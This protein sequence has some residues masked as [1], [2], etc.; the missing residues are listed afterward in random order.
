MHLPTKKKD[1]EVFLNIQSLSSTGVT[2]EQIQSVFEQFLVNI[3]INIA[4]GETAYFPFLGD[5]QVEYLGDT[6][7]DGKKEAQIKVTIDPCDSLKRLIGQI[8]DSNEGE[9]DLQELQIVK[10]MTLMDDKVM[11]NS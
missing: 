6:I 1:K 4:D 10:I 7:D 8:H 9:N 11:G 3:V 5:I 2:M